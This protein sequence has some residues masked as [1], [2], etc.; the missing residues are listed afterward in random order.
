[1]CASLPYETGSGV[2][3]GHCNKWIRNAFSRC[4][5]DQASRILRIEN[6]AYFDRQLSI[7]VS[8]VANGARCTELIYL[9]TLK[10]FQ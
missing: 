1:M 7:V 10:G 9:E 6:D 8:E 4:V 3:Y 2:S 5:L